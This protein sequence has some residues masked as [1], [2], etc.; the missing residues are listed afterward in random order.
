M[1]FRKWAACCERFILELQKPYEVWGDL[2]R[3]DKAVGA[4]VIWDMYYK[5]LC[6]QNLKYLEQNFDKPRCVLVDV[7]GTLALNTSKRSF[8]DLSQVGKDTP[9]PFVSCMVDALYNYGQDQNGAKYPTIIILSGREDTC[10]TETE[11]WLDKNFI[12][13]DKLYMR[14]AGDN[15]ADEIIKEE[16]YHEYIEPNYAVL[17]VVDDRPRVARMWRSLGFRVAQVGNPYLEF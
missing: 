16:M 14:K 10:R 11:N 8:Y 15:R 1:S 17:G 9:D 3:G 4:D 13:Y 6:P 2:H 7:D 5:W 12:P